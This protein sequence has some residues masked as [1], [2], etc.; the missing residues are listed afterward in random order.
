[1]INL[2]QPNLGDEELTLIKDVFTSNWLGKG[3]GVKDFE[4]KFAASLS[5]NSK[6]F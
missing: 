5:S 2:F 4:S 6:Q 3:S 1:M